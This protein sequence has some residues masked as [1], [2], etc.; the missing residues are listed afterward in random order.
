[1]TG[2]KEQ[3]QGKI[4]PTTGEKIP[5]A[6]GTT[7]TST[8]TGSSPPATAT[9]NSA[10]T[11]TL[12]QSLGGVDHNYRG[13]HKYFNDDFLGNFFDF[14]GPIG[15]T[16]IVAIIGLVLWLTSRKK[17]STDQASAKPSSPVKK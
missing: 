1:M 6:V 5:Q 8:N 12:N 2:I 4:D 7:A 16:A 15:L 3:V 14:I 11:D 10:T 17:K 9:P 13:K